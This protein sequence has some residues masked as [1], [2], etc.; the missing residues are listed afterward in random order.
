MTMAAPM[1]KVAW[2]MSIVVRPTATHRAITEGGDHDDHPDQAEFLSY[3]GED[4]IRTQLGYVWTLSTRPCARTEEASS[5]YGHHGLDDLVA[6]A[7]RCGPGI[8]ER[9]EPLA[10]IGLEH[11][12]PRYRHQPE[13]SRH[14]QIPRP[15]LGG[16]QRPCHTREQDNRG[17]EIWFE[18]NEYEEHP[19]GE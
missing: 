17:A 14:H 2:V 18:K 3:Q 6:R 10:A 1:L 4:H 15:Q 5:L 9:E 8:E 16:P 13:E 11:H 19:D 7:V 12:H